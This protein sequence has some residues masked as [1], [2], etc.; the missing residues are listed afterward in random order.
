MK[1]FKLNHSGSFAR[2]RSGQRGVMILEAMIAILIFSLGI[3]AL[4]ALQAA[5]IRL[6][7]DAKGRIDAAFLADKLIAQMWLS[8]PLTLANFEHNRTADANDPCIPGGGAASAMIT[9]WM[10]ENVLPSLPRA[11]AS[12]QRVTVLPGNVVEVS[13]CWQMPGETVN[14]H[15]YLARSTIVKNPPPTP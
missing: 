9:T 13:L 3:L 4:M 12:K 10:N 15:N 1:K 14:W 6:S 2:D 5:A 7:G 8:D 11:T